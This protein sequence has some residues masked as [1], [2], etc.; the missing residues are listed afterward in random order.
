MEVKICPNC[1]YQNY[2][3]AIVCRGCKQDISAIEITKIQNES[4]LSLSDI[5][6]CGIAGFIGGIIRAIFFYG[7]IGVPMFLLIL[8]LVA[9]VAGIVGAIITRAIWI[10]FDKK[11]NKSAIQIIIAFLAGFLPFSYY[12]MY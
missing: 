1:N 4:R 11:F 10:Q 2:A 7:T 8:P 12:M 5:I 3:F 9:P 6:I